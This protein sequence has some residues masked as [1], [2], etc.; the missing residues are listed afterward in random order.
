MSSWALLPTRLWI[1]DGHSQR[2]RAPAPALPTLQEELEAGL[3]FCGLAVMVNP[4]RADT[5]SV[6]AQ[7]HDADIRTV[8]VTGDHARTAVSV[9]HN[10]GMLC[11]N[12]PV[13][14]ADTATAEG[15]V[16][17]SELSLVAAAP[18]GSELPGNADQLLG[19]V[20]AGS[21][22]AAVTGRGF[23]KVGGWSIAVCCWLAGWL[24]GATC[25]TCRLPPTACCPP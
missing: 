13:A 5:T 1:V 18:D 25:G 3:R 24:L 16:Q 19:G 8:M 14:F 7:L 11:Q 20:A 21:L 22:A 9:A 10:C 12:R 2:C 23:E 17:D 15:R 6:I 4:L